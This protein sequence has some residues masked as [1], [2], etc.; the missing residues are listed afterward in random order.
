MRHDLLFLLARPTGLARIAPK[1]FLGLRPV[2]AIAPLRK[3]LTR[4]V[5]PV[6]PAFGE[7]SFFYKR[8]KLLM[9]TG[10][11]SIANAAPI[12]TVQHSVTQFSH[13]PMFGLGWPSSGRSL[14]FVW[15]WVQMQYR[16]ELEA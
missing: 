4:F 8:L 2:V 7:R 5:E 14:R 12:T 16:R 9:L 10:G 13:S 15:N 11:T 1:R 6:T 3:T